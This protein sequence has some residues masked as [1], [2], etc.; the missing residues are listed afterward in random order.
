M[1]KL[2]LVLLAAVLVLTPSCDF[3][4][5]INPFGKKA[6]EAE[7]LRQQQEAFRIADSIRVANEKQ[8]EAER[9]R[10]AEMAVAAEEQTRVMTGYHV[11]VGS[12]LT[13]EYADAWLE[14]IK[15][16]GYDAQLVGMNGGRWQLVSAQAFPNL[17]QAWNALGTVQDRINGEAWVY[18]QE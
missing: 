6:R 14:H 11:I 15:S 2:S 10:Q 5:S 3:M 17:H 7:A 12:F 8:A 9:A 16:F 18:R 13:P 1:K 4:K